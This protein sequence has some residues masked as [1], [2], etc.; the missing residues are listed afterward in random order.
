TPTC[1]RCCAQN[2]ARPEDHT[3]RED[4]AILTVGGAACQSILTIESM[5]G[6]DNAAPAV[7]GKAPRQ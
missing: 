3:A 7:E 5:A 2:R 6:P 1:E 4:G